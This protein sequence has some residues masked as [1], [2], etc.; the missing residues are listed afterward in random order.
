M[1]LAR[2]DT[3]NGIM[4]VCEID[5]TQVINRSH[6]KDRARIEPRAPRAWTGTS[7]RWGTVGWSAI[8]HT[9]QSAIEA[10][11]TRMRTHLATHQTHGLEAL[12]ASVTR[13]YH[14]GR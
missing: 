5:D 4:T 1:Y 8:D 10:V 14:A 11:L 12:I 7:A 9:R 3:A 6:N 2:C 13:R